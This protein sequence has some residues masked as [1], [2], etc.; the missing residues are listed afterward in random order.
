MSPRLKGTIFIMS[1]PAAVTVLACIRDHSASATFPGN[2]Q[3]AVKFSQSLSS[4]QGLAA[5][6]AVQPE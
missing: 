5:A 6:A 1:C 3:M 4:G 2:F